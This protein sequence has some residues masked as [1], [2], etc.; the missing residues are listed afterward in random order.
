MHKYIKIITYN[1]ACLKNSTFALIKC[2]H[3]H[4]GEN[5]CRS[6]EII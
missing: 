2:R 4:K 5:T 6:T 3:D 1:L